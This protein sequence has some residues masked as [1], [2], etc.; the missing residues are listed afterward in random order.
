MAPI[1]AVTKQATSQPAR[2]SACFIAA[3]CIMDIARPGEAV[4]ELIS[5]E[6]G[7]TRIAPFGIDFA[8]GM[9]LFYKATKGMASMDSGQVFP[10]ICL[11]LRKM[12]LTALDGAVLIN[13]LIAGFLA[14][15]EMAQCDQSAAA[16]VLQVDG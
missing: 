6:H 2:P 9:E 3:E 14:W 7:A 15:E 5:W 1:P 4:E 16:C 11:E 12:L 8:L 10:D 13:H